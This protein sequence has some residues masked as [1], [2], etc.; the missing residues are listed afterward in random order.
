MILNLLVDLFDELYDG[1]VALLGVFIFD[2]VTPI[3]KLC[4]QLQGRLLFELFDVPRA[5]GVGG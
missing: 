2:K 1:C 4:H 3:G 5:R